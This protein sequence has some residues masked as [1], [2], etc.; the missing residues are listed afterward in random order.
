MEIERLANSPISWLDIDNNVHY[1]P[2]DAVIY[3][4]TDSC[5]ISIKLDGGMVCVTTE[6]GAMEI[7]PNGANQIYIRA[8]EPI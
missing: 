1:L 3:I 4:D 8:G 2:A 7:R 6:D 5:T